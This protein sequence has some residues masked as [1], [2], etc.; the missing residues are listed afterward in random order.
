MK[1]MWSPNLSS[2][3]AILSFEPFFCQAVPCIVV[4]Q[5]NSPRHLQ[6]CISMKL[7]KVNETREERFTQ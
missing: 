6:T 4:A 5:L 3:E 2:S 1:N 7:I